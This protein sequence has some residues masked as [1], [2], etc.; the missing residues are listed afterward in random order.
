MTNG[1]WTALG[2]EIA[3]WRDCG[4]SVEF[5]WRDDDAALASGA[6]AQLLAL[7]ARYGVPLALAVIPERADPALLE[8]LLPTVTV[9]QHGTD[10][11]NRAG[12]GEKKTEFP[13][14]EP[15][16]AALARLAAA[17][18]RLQALSGGRPIDV[19]A[20]PWNRLPAPLAQNLA[21]A[22]FRG[23]SR[24]GSRAA[25]EARL[26]VAQANTHVDIIAWRADRGFVGEEAAISLAIRHLAARRTQAAVIDEATGWLTHHERHDAAA[27]RFLARLFETT[28]GQPGVRWRRADELLAP[29]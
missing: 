2:E 24:Y 21:Q 12:P 9:L 29:S 23:L 8:G 15:V 13:D 6:L 1:T 19:L 16:S 4:R 25:D 22:G 7:S 11:R 10:H 14:A 26:P 20:P 3:R 27:W 5:W 17:R 18:A 28:V